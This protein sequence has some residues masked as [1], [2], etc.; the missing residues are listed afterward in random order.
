MTIKWDVKAIQGMSRW[1][2]RVWSMCHDHANA[3]GQQSK[4]KLTQE[5]KKLLMS[6]KHEAIQKV[7]NLIFVVWL[8]LHI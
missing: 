2:Q 5:Q 6:A 8:R 3:C 1:L 7:Y 4:L